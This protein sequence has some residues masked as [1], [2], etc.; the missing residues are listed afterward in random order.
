MGKIVIL[1]TGCCNLTSLR[2]AVVRLGLEPV[3]TREAQ[4][5]SGASRLFVP[6]VGTAKAAMRELQNR[7]LIDAIKTASC[8]VLGICL[9]M[10]L[11]GRQSEETGG[12]PMLGI[13]DAPV[14]ELN[15]G[16]LPLPHMGWNRVRALDGDP[17]FDGMNQKAGDYFYFVHSYA[18]PVGTYTIATAEYGETFSAAVRSGLFWGVQF[19]PERSG[20]S[21]AKLLE[22]FVK[23]A[24]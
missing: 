7:G 17:L 14:R 19:H 8:P 4:V 1:D 22:N 2:A 16:G 12:V 21:G 18:Y 9:G 15:T 5:A 3:V 13:I 6:G 24:L 10:Q 23:G 20:K 11:L